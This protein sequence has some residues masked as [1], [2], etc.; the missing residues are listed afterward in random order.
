MADGACTVTPGGQL[1]LPDPLP[2]S[3]A[4]V[5]SS[6]IDQI[7]LLTQ[8]GGKIDQLTAAQTSLAVSM[9]LLQNALAPLAG[10]ETTLAEAVKQALT[11]T[12]LGEIKLPETF[13]IQGTGGADRGTKTIFNKKLVSADYIHAAFTIAEVLTKIHVKYIKTYSTAYEPF[14]L[15][16]RYWISQDDFGPLRTPPEG[17][18]LIPITQFTESVFWPNALYVPNEIYVDKRIEQVPTKLM[19]EYN[20][21]ADPLNDFLIMTEIGYDDII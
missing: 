6:A 15:W 8:L 21:T 16:Y 3:D 19:F 11:S 4:G 1:I 7:R 17:E 20:Q 12:T 2:V 10:L 5:R 9:S 14:I 18:Y 13:T